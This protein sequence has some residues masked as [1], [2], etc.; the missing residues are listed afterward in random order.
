MLEKIKKAG[1]LSDVDFDLLLSKLKVRTL[2]KGDHFL[3]IGNV[4]SD[5]AFIE[6]GLAMYYRVLDGDEIPVDFGV[7]GEWVSYL[8]SFSNQTPADLGIKMLEDSTLHYL[9]FSALG[10][11]LAVQPKFFALKAHYVE[12]SLISMAQ[13]SANLATLNAHDRYY[14]FM[15]EKPHLINRLPQYYIAAYLGIKPQSLSRIR[16]AGLS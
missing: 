2:K 14:K 11:L 6:K 16:K 9:S 1:N 15:L 8:Q 7:E 13:H 3:E 4:S 12:Q 10:E 5:L